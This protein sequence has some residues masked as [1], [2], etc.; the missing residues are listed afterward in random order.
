MFLRTRTKGLWNFI[1]PVLELLLYLMM[2]KI[3]KSIS[4]VKTNCNHSLILILFEYKFVVLIIE[5]RQAGY[6]TDMKWIII[7]PIIVCSMFLIRNMEFIQK[8]SNF[9]CFEISK[10]WKNP[11]QTLFFYLSVTEI[12]D[13]SKYKNT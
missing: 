3:L 10:T 8:F 13:N 6:I 2:F 1:V 5:D 11:V 12:H 4:I 9:F 7:K